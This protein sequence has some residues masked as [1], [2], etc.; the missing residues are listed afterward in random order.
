MARRLTTEE[1][2]DKAKSVHGDKYG[3]SDVVYVNAHSKVTILCKEH[4][5][6]EQTPNSH[7]S[8]KGCPKCSPTYIKTTE[9][10]INDSIL[11]HGQS[12]N[13]SLVD[14]KGSN[15][16]VDI[17][18][19]YHGL[20]RQEPSVHIKGHGCP[21]CRNVKLRNK[22]KK[23]TEQFVK[24][25]KRIHGNKYEY[26]SCCYINNYTDVKIICK[27]H[28]EF[29][30]TPYN[31][32][33]GSEC[34]KCIVDFTKNN[35]SGWSITNWQMAGERS[36]NF[37]S[38]K[39]YIIKCWNDKEVFYKIGRTFKEVKKRFHCNH[40]MPYNYEIVKEFIFDN[41]KD[42]FNKEVD[43]KRFN[44]EFKYIPLKTFG[45]MHECFKELKKN[46]Q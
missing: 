19:E 26:S 29:N 14:Y 38:F 33:N 24:E 30:Q 25:A 32:L 9:K 23:T 35:P 3:Y 8:G 16:K 37:N 34:P 44:K 39:V 21:E 42:A 45:G 13:Y 40:R 2:I 1:F 15:I 20:F 12:Y 31:H 28:G 41:A 6:F 4:G 5:D 7:L 46:E 11:I 17:L 18:C 36:K 43:L 27:I 22:Y 10:F